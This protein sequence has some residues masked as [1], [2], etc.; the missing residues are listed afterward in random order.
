[1]KRSH[2]DKSKRYPNIYIQESSIPKKK[3]IYF[4]FIYIYIEEQF[5]LFDQLKCN[6]IKSNQNVIKSN[7]IKMQIFDIFF[8]YFHLNNE[9]F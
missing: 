2:D 6:Q 5:K 1:M 8:L 4:V 9:N 7:Q 3:Y